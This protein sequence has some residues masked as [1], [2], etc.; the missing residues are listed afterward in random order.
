M[1][2]IASDKDVINIHEDEYSN[3]I[4]ILCEQ[5]CVNSRHTKTMTN[6]KVQEKAELQSWGLFETLELSMDLK[7]LGIESREKR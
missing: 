5:R 2:S 4:P 7:I 6:N 1:G 3:T